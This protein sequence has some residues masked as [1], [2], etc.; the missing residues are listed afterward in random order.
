ME[1]M[2]AVTP[3]DKLE[4]QV[5]VDNTTDVLSSTPDYAQSELIYLLRTGRMAS[6]TAGGLC[7]AAHGFS[8]LTTAYR[9][10]QKHTLLFDSGP[11]PYAFV[12][13]CQRLNADLG[14]VEAVLLSHGHFDHAGGFLDAL[15]HIRENNGNRSVPFYGHPDMFRSRGLMLPNKAML[16]FEDIPADDALTAHGAQ[17]A[18]SKTSEVVLDGMFGISGEIPRVTPFERGF[19]AHYRRTVDGKDW[20]PDPLI[21]DERFLAVNVAG[22]GLIVF[23]G[24]SHA[25]IINV[26]QCA[27]SE[28]PDTPIFGLIGGLHLA[29]PN[30][31]LI[32]QTVDAMRQFRLAVIAVGHCTGWRAVNALMTAFGDGVISPCAVGKRYAF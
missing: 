6:M 4:V 30:E 25:G 9:G 16:P 2:L 31:A 7:C 8:C 1:A 26:L 5:L 12:R 15:D 14:S 20:E 24:C 27:R 13:N 19:P 18:L 32:E 3:V 17:L 11:E 21:M 22:K 29:G 23:S 28:A 10:S